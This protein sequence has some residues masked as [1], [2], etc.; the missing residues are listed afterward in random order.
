MDKISNLLCFLAIV[1]AATVT[2]LIP[3]VAPDTSYPLVIA[4]GIA[5]GVS[6]LVLRVVYD[7]IRPPIYWWGLKRGLWGKE[8]R[9]SLIAAG[10]TDD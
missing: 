4:G 3:V 10:M 7:I 9:D 6:L 2:A 8:L 1:V 5:G